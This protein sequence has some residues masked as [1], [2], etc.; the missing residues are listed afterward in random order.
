MTKLKS[1]ILCVPFNVVASLLITCV[2]VACGGN[3]N[4]P[5]TAQDAALPDQA[6]S[7]GP[8]IIQSVDIK[9]QPQGT[10][11][12]FK[13]TKEMMPN[14]FKLE[15]PDRIVIDFTDTTLGAVNT[16]FNIGDS[17]VSR[18]V[19][20]QFDEGEGSLSRAEIALN[21][22]AE[23]QLD[24][25]NTSLI[26][27]IGDVDDPV[28]LVE[29]ASP[30][31]FDQALTQGSADD[32]L[33]LDQIF[34]VDD[35]IQDDAFSLTETPVESIDLP[36]LS[37]NVFDPLV[38]EPSFSPEPVDVPTSVTVASI[39][40]VDHVTS[41]EGT[42]IT[43]TGSQPIGLIEEQT[44]TGPNRLV[45]DLQSFDQVDLINKTL[46]IGTSEV[47]Q[48]R[49]GEND[50]FARVVLD[51]NGELPEYQVS[52]NQDQVTIMVNRLSPEPVAQMFE[53]VVEATP[54]AEDV[55]LDAVA[56]TVFE[57]P[58][59]VNIDVSQEITNRKRVVVEAVEFEQRSDLNTSR[60]VLGVNRDDV[61]FNV[62]KVS[63]DQL[64]VYIPN[65]KFKTAL[66]KRHLDTSQYTSHVD[67][68]TPKHHA[69]EK[70]VSFLIDVNGTDANYD[71]V[72]DGKQI[73]LDF[74]MPSGQRLAQ[75]D[76]PVDNLPSLDSG[77]IDDGES[78]DPTEIELG[79]VPTS[80]LAEPGSSAM[81]SQ[82]KKNYKY[83][84]E[85][86]MSDNVRGEGP[87]SH[88]GQILAGNIEGKRF[89][90]R[91]ISLDINDADIRSVFRLIADISKFN[92]I[93]SDE[94]DG[95]VTIK[96]DDVP[97]D[98]AF[99]IVLQ[100][101]GLWFEKYGSIVRVAP[102]EKL[103]KEKESAAAAQAAAQAVKPL[104]ILFK[105]VSFA[106][107]DTLTKQIGSILT[108]RGSVDIDSRTNTLIIKDIR[109][110]LEKAKKMVDILD[111]QTPQVSI[112]ARIVEATD[113]FGRS[114]GVRWSGNTRFSAATGNP[115]G[116]WFPN[117]INIPFALDFS[118]VSTPLH[119]AGIQMGS[120]NNIFDLDL[121]LSF[122]EQT[123]ESKLISA[124]KVTVLDNTPATISSGTRIPFITQ[125]ADSGSNVRFENAAT[126]LTV[127][128][129]ITNE[130]SVL[131]QIT[132]SRSFPSEAVIVQGNPAIEQRTATTQVLVKSGNTTV[133]G[134]I[135]SLRSGKIKQKIPFLSN[136]PVIGAIFQ[137]HDKSME[138]NEL[139]IFV[140]PRIVGDERE[141]IR[142]IRQ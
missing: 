59:T 61:Q 3:K 1:K 106:A 114:L 79:D 42:Q 4:A 139:L 16:E 141:A 17:T 30:D 9:S 10:V 137:N 14:I 66:L 125:T 63:N 39:V 82:P 81:P 62:L 8:N 23:Y 53:P 15:D 86:F 131:M 51:I 96:L 89:S 50:G 19:M 111:T 110:N 84:E 93:I 48:V 29:N 119:T 132:A 56:T 54:A 91:K 77:F 20:E 13:G 24:S 73:Y 60:L 94:V 28:G 85:S 36:A 83:V 95:R 5:S 97:W 121:Q 78:I 67:K 6:L 136:I 18:L 26:I 80:T 70:A 74:P 109:E 87:L 90:G 32:E 49:V 46:S 68:V 105:P 115:T 25:L 75:N 37:D 116:L 12:A 102:S 72:Q 35:D 71:L 124:P 113:S 135:Y 130:G 100:S 126:T 107:A 134:G 117:N 33:G 101:K 98:Q 128:P 140:T 122:G 52:K 38:A 27:T 138:R 2:L 108:E 45:F 41:G 92:L 65:A 103:Q 99:A 127:T 47:S 40:N 7:T 22:P 69:S 123:G 118:Q 43:I 120:I 64:R 112:E 55:P 104:D 31:L 58:S 88:M 11:I 133:L 57:D 142:D 21:L 44:L 34:S 76:M 129:H